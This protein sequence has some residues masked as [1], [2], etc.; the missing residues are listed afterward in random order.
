MSTTLVPRA[1]RTCSSSS[2]SACNMSFA[3][4]GP[5]DSAILLTARNLMSSLGSDTNGAAAIVAGGRNFC[6]RSI[7]DKS[8]H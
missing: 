7:A 5:P 6:V 4:S 2:S 3:V 1:A 8:L